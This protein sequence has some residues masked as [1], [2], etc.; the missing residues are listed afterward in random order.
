MTFTAWPSKLNRRLTPAQ[1]RMVRDGWPLAKASGWTQLDWCQDVAAL[2]GLH[3][4]FI[5][6]VLYHVNYQDVE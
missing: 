2:L 5:R 3:H 1:V 4:S 6:S